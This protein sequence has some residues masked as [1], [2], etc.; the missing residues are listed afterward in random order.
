MYLICSKS[1]RSVWHSDIKLALCSL[2]LNIQL[3]AG[4]QCVRSAA[5]GLAGAPSTFVT[6]VPVA[7][8]TQNSPNPYLDQTEVVPSGIHKLGGPHMCHPWAEQ[9]HTLVSRPSFAQ[10]VTGGGEVR[11]GCHFVNKSNSR[12]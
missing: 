12:V 4:A 6:G 8:H 5:P 11:N 1:R 3:H 7:D 9:S 10:G 2:K